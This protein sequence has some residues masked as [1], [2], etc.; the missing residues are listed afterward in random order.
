MSAQSGLSLS[1]KLRLK[2]FALN[3]QVTVADTFVLLVK[4]VHFNV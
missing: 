3:N 1:M 4:G 2:R